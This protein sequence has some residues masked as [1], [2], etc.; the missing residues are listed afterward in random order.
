MPRYSLRT[1]LILLAIG[2]PMLWAL[3]PIAEDALWP[4]KP[5]DKVDLFAPLTSDLRDIWVV[6]KATITVE[7][8]EE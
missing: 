5:M 8:P 6:D 4:P 2:P 7:Q 1:L 3:W